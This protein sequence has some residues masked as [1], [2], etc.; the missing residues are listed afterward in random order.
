MCQPIAMNEQRAII[1]TKLVHEDKFILITLIRETVSAIG[2][3]HQDFSLF[4]A[5][6]LH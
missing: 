2:I 4:V 6:H 1:S 5:G 3:L